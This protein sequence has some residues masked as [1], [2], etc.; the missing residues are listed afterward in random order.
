MRIAVFGTG[1]VG[2]YFGGRLAEAGEKLVFIARGRHL[3]AIRRDGLRVASIL[4]DFTVAP[5]EAT[6]DPA[7]GGP[8]D[9][10][11][12][13]VKA[14]QVP[15]AAQAMRPLLGP[16]TLVVPLQNGIEAAD[17]LQAVLGTRPVLGGLCRV[18]AWLDGPGQIRHAGL[19]PAIAFGELDG[20]QSPRA[21]RLREVFRRARGVTV[22]TPRD[23]RTALWGKLM[24]I[25]SVGA[26]GAASRAPAGAFRSQ[27]ETR[28]LLAAVA[29]EVLALARASGAAL[30]EEAVAKILTAVDG[31]PETATSSMQ[32]DV[33]EGRPSELEAQLGAV[34]R[35]ARQK[36]V[37]APVTSVLYASLLP[38]ER[39]ARGEIAF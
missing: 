22:E 24:F 29:R 31:L 37:P 12:L 30:T 35:L 2:G 18:L 34:V 28:E 19:T 33:L 10:V 36:G 17:Q 4:G 25:A 13:G 7:K 9:A 32:R 20:S 39:K 15:E 38:L 1:A 6:D 26:V 8:V 21:E 27:A 3:E 16:D 14:W 23:I 11:L 5:A